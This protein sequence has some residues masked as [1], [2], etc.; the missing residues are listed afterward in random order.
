MKSSAV[1]A[2]WASTVSLRPLDSA[3]AEPQ[4]IPVG[5]A[6]TSAIRSAMSTAMPVGAVKRPP[7]R[8]GVVAELCRGSTRPLDVLRSRRRHEDRH[9][10]RAAFLD[11]GA[12]AT[13]RDL[14]AD[15]V[16]N[17]RGH[18]PVA[19]LLERDLGPC[20]NIMRQRHADH[21]VGAFRQRVRRPLL[22]ATRRDASEHPVTTPGPRRCRLEVRRIGSLD[23]VPP[24]WT[25]TRSAPW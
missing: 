12:G 3:E 19:E 15:R 20:A 11:R 16:S 23:E 7:L 10:R 4:K 22:A 13:E 17:P 21:L 2:A 18:S 25:R 8:R 9:V 1:S 14:E 6:S 24:N 5:S